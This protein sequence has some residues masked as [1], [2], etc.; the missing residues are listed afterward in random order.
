MKFKKASDGHFYLQGP[1]FPGGPLVTYQLKEQALLQLQK[2]GI[3][4]DSKVPPN[5]VDKLRSED[6]IF[7]GGSGVGESTSESPPAHW[8]LHPLILW[9][10]RGSISKLKVALEQA[11]VTLSELV[12]NPF[13]TWL[14]QIGVGVN[15]SDLVTCP[16]ER[17]YLLS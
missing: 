13:L 3:T 14:C 15:L 11:H 2:W 6:W 9:A 10:D 16:H 8:N 7:T 12:T 4:V 1:P 17:V 5:F